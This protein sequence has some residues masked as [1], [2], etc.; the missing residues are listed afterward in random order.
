M[1][2]TSLTPIKEI[3]KEAKKGK[4]REKDAYPHLQSAAITKQHVAITNR[5]TL[6]SRRQ[7]RQTSNAPQPSADKQRSPAVGRQAVGRPK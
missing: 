7:T 2:K 5:A 6:P 1:S 3:I 4:I